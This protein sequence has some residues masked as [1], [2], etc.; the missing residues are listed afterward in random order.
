MFLV[1]NSLK[2]SSIK[3]ID[4]GAKEFN[5]LNPFTS[6]SLRLLLNR[7]SEVNVQSTWPS[8]TVTFTS[9]ILT[10][11]LAFTVAVAPITVVFDNAEV[12]TFAA[13][14]SAVLF[15]PVVILLSE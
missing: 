11:L 12:E 1:K 10:L 15:D 7:P 13:Y 14:P 8:I 9:P 3:V 2:P 4:D 6:L 5:E